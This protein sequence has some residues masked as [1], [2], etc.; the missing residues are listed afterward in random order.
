MPSMK[1]AD[2]VAP[3]PPPALSPRFDEALMLASELHARQLRMG[4]TIPYVSHLLGVASIALEYGADE[5][6]ATA[7]LLHDAIEDQGGAGTEGLIPERVGAGGAGRVRA[8]S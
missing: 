2:P 5:E 4:T 7:A 8:R 3:E 1:A 6:T